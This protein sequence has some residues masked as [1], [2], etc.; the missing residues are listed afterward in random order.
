MAAHR[1]ALCGLAACVDRF[2]QSLQT[3]VSLC[4]DETMLALCSDKEG[5]TIAL[6]ARDLHLFRVLASYR[7]LPSTYLHAF[8]GGAAATRFKER[9]EN[10]FHEGF[11]DRPRQQWAHFNAHCRPAVSARAVR[12]LKEQGDETPAQTF[13]RPVAHRQFEHALLIGLALAS[14]EIAA[15]AQ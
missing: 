14:I 9:L 5:K 3:L 15:R 12:V 6:T 11:L 7:Y 1:D 13:L 2:G 8:A 4:D 10:L